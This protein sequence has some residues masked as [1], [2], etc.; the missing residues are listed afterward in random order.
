VPDSPTQ[1]NK[2]RPPLLCPSNHEELLALMQGDTPELFPFCRELAAYLLLAFSLWPNDQERLLDAA[3]IYSGAL[4]YHIAQTPKNRIFRG[5]MEG[6][7]KVRF[8]RLFPTSDLK[9][10]N[11]IFFER[12]GSQKSLLFC[13]SVKQFRRDL[14]DRTEDLK[15]VHDVIEFLIKAATVLPSK[16]RSQVSPTRR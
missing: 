16:L 5:G 1:G 15:M 12:I 7:E 9:S 10:F 13:P 4:N 3:R 2:S 14:I 11:R 8:G 6:R